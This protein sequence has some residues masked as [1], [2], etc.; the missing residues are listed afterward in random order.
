MNSVK[1]SRKK[2]SKKLAPISPESAIQI[3]CVAWFDLQYKGK[4]VLFHIPNAVAFAG[5]NRRKFYAVLAKLK[6]EGLRKGVPDL[7]LVKP[8]GAFSGLFIEMKAG[9]N[10]PTPEQNQMMRKFKEDG[11]ACC[12][13]KSLKDFK[14]A[15]TT[16]LNQPD[17][18]LPC[19]G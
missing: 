13:C 3:S 9:Y 7:F 17:D 1:K 2:S 16:Y 8:S 14:K 4:Y 5:G 19:D 6:R 12:I 11:Y 15:I 18:F 10:K